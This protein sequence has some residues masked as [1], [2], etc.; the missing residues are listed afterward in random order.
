MELKEQ[1]A[2][3]WPHRP[4]L[5]RCN[6]PPAPQVDQRV[7]NLPAMQETWIQ[8]LVQEDPLEDSMETHSRILA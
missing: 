5:S 7:E 8:S 2:D 6:Q 3:R 4:G 1:P